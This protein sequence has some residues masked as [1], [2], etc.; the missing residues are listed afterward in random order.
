MKC[1]TNACFWTVLCT[2]LSLQCYTYQTDALQV[3]S[4]P[5]LLDVPT[6]SLATIDEKGSTGMNILTYASPVS[7][8]P[9]RMFAIGL[10][11]GTSTYENFA[12][13]GEG[14]LQLLA[15]CHA[16]VVKILGGSS[17]KDDHVDKQAACEKVGITWI[18]SEIE[19]F[20]EILLLPDCRYYLKLKMVGDLIDCGSHEVALCKVESM[21]IKDEVDENN[22][23]LYLNSASLR[24]QGIIT[25]QGRV[26]E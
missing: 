1:F 12:R 7:V 18:A 13:S 25:E 15:P 20:P 26:A 3:T 5:P 19:T 6:Y 21:H 2:I 22:Q 23:E 10:F 17:S 24:E 14:V 4:V 8:R 11:K 16:D 9:D